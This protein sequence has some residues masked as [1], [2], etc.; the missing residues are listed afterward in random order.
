MV[1]IERRN[2]C[3][4]LGPSAL[5]V[6]SNLSQSARSGSDWIVI[7]PR[8]Y[9]RATRRGSKNEQAVALPDFSLQESLLKRSYWDT[10]FTIGKGV[11]FLSTPVRK[12]DQTDLN[13][14]PHSQ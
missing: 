1:H 7:S 3:V 4:R 8:G 11:I 9:L 2:A 5:R 13:M 10:K 14:G 6:A 12:E